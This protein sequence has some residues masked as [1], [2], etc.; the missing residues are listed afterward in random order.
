LTSKT[1]YKHYFGIEVVYK[2]D[3]TTRI[4]RS[5]QISNDERCSWPIIVKCDILAMRKGSFILRS[6]IKISHSTSD[7]TLQNVY[8]Q[9]INT[10]VDKDQKVLVTL[11]CTEVAELWQTHGSTTHPGFQASSYFQAAAVDFMQRWP[12]RP[13][14][15]DS[16][17][18][19]HNKITKQIR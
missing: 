9:V 18:S 12:I 3:G 16:R 6:R 10:D 19:R 5:S 8:V 7:L 2:A 13:W 17:S 4:P 14:P 11:V 1:S 15:P